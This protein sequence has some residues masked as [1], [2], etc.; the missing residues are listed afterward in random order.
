MSDELKKKIGQL[1]VIGWDGINPSDDFLQMVNEWGVGGAIIFARNISDPRKIPETLRK[2]EN[3][4]G[5]KI[6]T[7]IDQEGGLVLRVLSGGSLFP[8]AMA[9]GATGDVEL[10]RR[11]YEALALEM[12]ALGLNWNLAPVLDVNSIQNPGIGARSFGDSPTNVKIFGQAAIRGMRSGGVLSCAKHFPGKGAAKVDSHLSLPVISFSRDELFQRDLKPFIG[13]IEEG[14]DAIMTSHVFFPAFEKQQNLPAT[15]SKS[16]MTGL[17]RNEL[18]YDGLLISDD[19]EM[20]AITE[21]YGVAEAAKRAFL[22][23]SDQLAICH[24]L[25]WQKNALEAVY[26]EVKSS[27]EARQRLDE[28][29]V[30]ISKAK[31]KLENFSSNESIIEL[32]K[33]HSSLISEAHQKSVLFWRYSENILPIKKETAFLVV[34]PK[35]SAL[36]P[37][38]ECQK[39]DGLAAFFKERFPSGISCAYEPKASCEEILSRVTPLIDKLD[40]EIPILLLSYNA[41]LFEG[42]KNAFSLIAEKHKKSIL[43]ALRNPYD[44]SAIS[45]PAIAIAV[46]G[47]RTPSLE[48]LC[49]ALSGKI[50]PKF[51]PWPVDL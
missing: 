28:S 34:G 8:G 20:G 41:H 7:S 6:F 49:D 21:T 27:E 5:T 11:T 26:N 30:R 50:A 37:V 3:A 40:P 31:R 22:A 35:I 17:L 36:V 25:K 9:L 32:Q 45:E 15:L 44:V 24:E 13:A 1:F 48:A 51:G 42:Q 43:A 39:E 47:F 23:G 12:L 33:R 16:V 2:I 18:H 10:T 19:L 29:L 14:V 4:A 38:E 46:F